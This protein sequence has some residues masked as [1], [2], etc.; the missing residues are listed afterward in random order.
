MLF[1]CFEKYTNLPFTKKIT[2]VRDNLNPQLHSLFIIFQPFP[3]HPFHQ[4]RKE[5][6][7]RIFVFSLFFLTKKRAALAFPLMK[8][9]LVAFDEGNPIMNRENYSQVPF[10]MSRFAF[11]NFD[12]INFC[13]Y[14]NMTAFDLMSFCIGFMVIVCNWFQIL[15]NI[16]CWIFRCMSI[17]VVLNFWNSILVRVIPKPAL[18]QLYNGLMWV[19]SCVALKAYHCY[20]PRIML[21]LA[22]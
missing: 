4:R 10:G 22:R 3:C 18:S 6:G 14:W 2:H 20:T 17:N 16:W 15:L 11:V 13:S 9:F 21:L 7:T 19:I 1:F 8:P 5:S 12:W